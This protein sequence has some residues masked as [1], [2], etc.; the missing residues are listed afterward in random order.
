MPLMFYWGLKTPMQTK[1]QLVFSPSVCGLVHHAQLHIQAFLDDIAKAIIKPV[2][3]EYFN[4][5]IVSNILLAID[6]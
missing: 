4:S 1:L 3:I 5:L 2:S 6:K